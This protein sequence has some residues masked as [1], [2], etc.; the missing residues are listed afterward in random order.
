MSEKITEKTAGQI[1]EKLPVL[2]TSVNNQIANV[3]RQGDRGTEFYDNVAIKS[4]KASFKEAKTDNMNDKIV[5]SLQA[6]I[7]QQNNR[8]T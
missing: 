8:R 7:T 1:T 4:I 5:A 3:D 6:Q 2:K